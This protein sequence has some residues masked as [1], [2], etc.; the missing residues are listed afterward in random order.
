MSYIVAYLHTKIN[1]LFLTFVFLRQDVSLGESADKADISIDE[2][3]RMATKRLQKA[4]DEQRQLN[5]L[6]EKKAQEI[7]NKDGK[8]KGMI[9]TTAYTRKL[10]AMKI[11]ETKDEIKNAIEE[12][13]SIHAAEEKRNKAEKA[14]EAAGN[15]L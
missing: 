7:F 6:A 5:K 2:A 8:D 11:P 9:E 1:Q 12:M 13:E 14:D 4:Q 10:A 15:G 3:I